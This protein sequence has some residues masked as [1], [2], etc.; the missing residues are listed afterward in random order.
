ML[1]RFKSKFSRIFSTLAEPFNRIGLKPN[2][3][4]VLSLVLSVIFFYSIVNE[5]F[6]Y[7]FI[8]I[9]LISLL[10]ALDGA[11]ARKTKKES[12]S[13]SYLDTIVDRYVE[14]IILF[15]LLLITLPKVIFPSYIWITLA[16]FGSLITTYSKAAY[17]EKTGKKFEGGFF[18]RG[19]R[20][21]LLILIVFAGIFS[22]FYL[23]HLLILFS[24]LTNTSALHRII[25]SL[26]LCTR[27]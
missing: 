27:K 19:E 12:V 9:L 4:T 15:P 14:F 8:L 24:V 21:L 16:I 11:L 10:D 1:S 7:A 2:H 6:I 23:I 5:F 13:G 3:L 22:F 18:E 20:M 17:S 25:L 26:K